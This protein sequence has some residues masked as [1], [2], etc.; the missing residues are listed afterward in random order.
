MPGTTRDSIDSPLNY[1]GEKLLFIDTAGL[2]R[3]SRIKESIEYYSFIRAIKSIRRASVV[4]LVIDAGIKITKQDKQIISE[5]EESRKG[6]I[7][8]L[9]KSDVI[10]REKRKEV[11]NYYR[12]QLQFVEFTPMIYTSAITGEGIQDLLNLAITV[13]RNRL[14]K[15]GKKRLL[16]SLKSSYIKMPPPLYGR[17]RAKIIDVEQKGPGMIFVYT[18]IKNAFSNQYIRYLKKRLYQ[19]FPFEGIPLKIKVEEKE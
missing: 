10:P 13:H 5:V 15:I 2:K 6:M 9:H 1:N 18:N 17:K 7:I 4:F 8:V 12:H 14:R 11:M 3:K 16:K 19:D